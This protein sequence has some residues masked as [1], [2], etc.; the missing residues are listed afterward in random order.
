MSMYAKKYISKVM[1]PKL[2]NDPES[3]NVTEVDVE[4]M[5]VNVLKHFNTL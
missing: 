4:G 5:Q 1:D 3:D 2:A